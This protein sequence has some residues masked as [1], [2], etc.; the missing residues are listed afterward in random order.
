MFDHTVISTD[1]NATLGGLL[2]F[3]VEYD[4]GL[5]GM[6][7][8]VKQVFCATSNMVYVFTFTSDATYYEQHLPAVNEMLRMFTF[9]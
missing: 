8:R 4:T 1:E 7:Y 5:T 9:D 2:A 3:A 6:M